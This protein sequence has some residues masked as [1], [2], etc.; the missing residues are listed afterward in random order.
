MSKKLRALSDEDV[1]TRWNQRMARVRQDLHYVYSTR[2][3]FNDVASLF[4]RNEELKSIGGG[5]YDWMFRMWSRDIVIAIRREL[6][7]DANTVCLG[8]LLDEMAQR[9]RV[10][11]RARYLGD[12]P[13]GDFRY[14]MLWKTFDGFGV[15]RQSATSPLTDYLDP[16][17]IAA[18]RQH[19]A[20]IAKPV[21]A[22]ANQLIAH[23]SETEHV[24]VT[25]G[26]VNRTVKAIEEAFI[27][28]YAIIVG[29][30]LMGLEPSHIGNWL[31]PFEIPWITTG[32]R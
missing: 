21:V 6:D 19:L 12:I 32:E 25:L 5:V 16:A 3:N 2:R 30:S 4:E 7:S 26:D 8:R 28:Y 24:P 31:A 18:D 9:P 17:G 14:Q 15:I 22:F 23:R 11:T 10:I 13:E 27:K 29:P 20:K 1:W